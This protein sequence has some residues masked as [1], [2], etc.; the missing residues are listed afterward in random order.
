[1]LNGIV[2]SLM[3]STTLS[4]LFLVPQSSLQPRPATAPAVDELISKGF[5]LGREM[6]RAEA[7]KVLGKPVSVSENQVKGHRL[8]TLRFAGL[9]VELRQDTDGSHS[10]IS[11]IELSDNRWQFPAKL[12]IG[13]TRDDMLRL[14]GKPDIDRPA[15][16]VYGCYECVYDDKIHVMFDGNKIK[17]M[18]WDFYLD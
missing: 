14:L 16:S 15:E 18:K 12:R 7:E 11:S 10:V 6:T 4:V 1:M 9:V 13:S 8:T 5:P 2:S 17:S 3:A